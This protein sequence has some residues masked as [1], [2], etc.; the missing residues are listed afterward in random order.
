MSISMNKTMLT[1]LCY[2]IREKKAPNAPKQRVNTQCALFGLW[3][4]MLLWSCWSER[5]TKMPFNPTKYWFMSINLSVLIL[6][7]PL[8]IPF[9][10]QFVKSSWKIGFDFEI[11]NNL[12]NCNP[13][14][15]VFDNLTWIS[16]ENADTNKIDENLN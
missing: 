14:A 7:E 8:K 1:L 3:K 15:H 4:F 9:E 2:S 16:T 6:R 11:R 10:C 12:S 5:C 13:S